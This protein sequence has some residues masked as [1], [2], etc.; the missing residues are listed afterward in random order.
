MIETTI[1]L[2]PRE[3][4]RPGMTLEKL[5]AELDE[6]VQVPSLNNAWLMPI[7]TRI[8]MQSTG[9]NTPVGIKI[10][11]P[12]LQVIE[13]I[14]EDIERVLHGVEGTR[15]VY[16]ER[17]ASARY[18]DIAINRNA[19]TRYS[20][21]MDEIQE[22]INIAVGGS[23]VMW[24][25]E[26]RERYPVNLRYPRDVRD[27]LEKLR[28]LPIVTASQEELQLRD[29]AEV[30]IVDGPPLIRSEDARLN[31]RVYVTIGNRDLGSY[32]AAAQQAIAEQVTLPAGYT[33]TWAGQ[34]E[35]MQ[36]AW[37]RLSWIVPLTLAIILVLLYL[38]FRSFTQALLVIAAVPLS[39]VG[40]I[41]LV[42]FLGYE[43]SVA[44][45]VGFI[46][47]AGVAAEFGVVMMVYLDEAV[48][49]HRP[50]TLQELRTAVIEGAVQRVRPK[51]MTAAVII[52]GLLPIMLGGGTGSEVMRR[53]AAPLVGGMV[54]APLVSMLLIPV[55]YLWWKGRG[56]G[57]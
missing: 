8:D 43:L 36:R 48:K 14:G 56:L 18:I 17:T 28:D 45:A 55:L 46:A 21:T 9:I 4:W 11:G 13:A 44:V 51:A 22:V 57:E 16:S 30:D 29:V 52:A 25:V 50:A 10:A 32:I 2:K 35:Y 38:S 49:R 37:Q 31:G 34:Y 33:L 1:K 47:L 20:T 53:I 41:W 3:Q 39:L 12:D 27:S 7:K 26:G 40:G 42:Y 15:S 19:L 54:T 5:K 6:R 23:N 24:T